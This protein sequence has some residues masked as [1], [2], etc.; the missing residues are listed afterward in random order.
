ML[1]IYVLIDG[2]IEATTAEQNI[3]SVEL[4]N[5]MTVL[6]KNLNVDGMHF[7]D[8]TLAVAHRDKQLRESND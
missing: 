3:Y 1:R 4:R 2:F 8:L 7:T 6:D 5:G